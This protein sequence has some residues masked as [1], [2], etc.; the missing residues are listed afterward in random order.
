MESY[1][2]CGKSGLLPF[3]L[4]QL[5]FCFAY[6]SL[7][8][9]FSWI[10]DKNQHK[11]TVCIMQRCSMSSM[12]LSFN[13]KR[14]YI[15][16]C[17]Y[18]CEIPLETHRGI[19]ISDT[20]EDGN[21]TQY[22]HNLNKSRINFWINKII[23]QLLLDIQTLFFSISSQWQSSPSPVSQCNRETASSSLNGNK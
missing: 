21:I 10:Y 13:R 20:S 9:T 22:W 2:K 6:C 3:P 15:S 4:I 16:L 8:W 11:G 17:S 12:L 1:L 5:T 23:G 19:S 18:R 14:L 7:P